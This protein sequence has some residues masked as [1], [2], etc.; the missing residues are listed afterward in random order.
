MIVVSDLAKGS[1]L[2]IYKQIY[3]QVKHLEISILV[4]N[5]GLLCHG[6]FLDNSAKALN[7]QI[8]VK[9][10]AVVH[11]T[12]TILPLLNN[13]THHRSAIINMSSVSAIYPT[14]FMAVYAASKAFTD[15]FSRGLVAE[16]PKID[17]LTARPGFL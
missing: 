16:H 10:L 15:Y 5:A 7:D 13:R 12:H 11:L 2:E 3:E 6:A 17:I 4:N 8:I 14:S 1:D 9:S